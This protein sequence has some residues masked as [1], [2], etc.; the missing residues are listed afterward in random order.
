[1]RVAVEQLPVVLGLMLAC[2]AAA[3]IVSTANSF[4]LTPASALMRDVYQP[5][6]NPRVTDRQVVVYTRALVVLL[7]GLGLIALQFFRTIL[8]M[9]LWAY[10]MY[11]AAITPALL[12]AFLWPR[13]TRQGGVASIATGMIVTLAWE[14]GARMM[15]GPDGSPA[16]AFNLPTV[17]P[18][19]V[20][21]VVALVAVSLATKAPTREE[22][23]PLQ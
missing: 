7:G 9:A 19:F 16:Y 5:F 15:A 2:G 14:I 3:I 11:G 1:M 13:A 21:S 17:Y 12:A 18:A 20:M 6:I 22:L 23:V 10:T 8:E 4:L